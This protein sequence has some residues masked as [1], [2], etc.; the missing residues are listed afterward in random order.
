MLCNFWEHRQSQLG[1]TLQQ[2][3]FRP[4]LLPSLFL[5]CLI[6]QEASAQT[7]VILRKLIFVESE[8]AIVS[9]QNDQDGDAAVYANDIPFL[10]S[11]EANKALSP[12]IGQQI[13]IPLI[14]QIGGIVKE[15]A[16]KANLSAEL[17][18]PNQDARNGV[19]RLIVRSTKLA[20][21]EAF[22][23]KK[24][25]FGASETTLAAI[26]ADAGGSA[27]AYSQDFPF[28]AD[29]EA[30]KA[31]APFVGKQ[32]TMP[33]LNEIGGVVKA[34]A[35]KNDRVV[36]LVL[37]GQDVKGGT[38][39]YL[40]VPTKLIGVR[41]RGN[42]WFSNKVL[43]NNLGIKLGS[44]IRVSELEDAVNWTNTNPFRQIRVLVNKNGNET[45]KAELVVG[46]DESRPYRLIG[47]YD[48]SGTANAGRNRYTAAVQFG[49]LW[50][51]DHQ[52]AYQ[53]V[54]TED[55]KVYNGHSLTYTI[56][57][58]WRN[59]LEL[60]ASYST[61][62]PTGV[63]VYD[64]LKG[65]SRGGSIRYRIPTGGAISSTEYFVG[66]DAQQSN[67]VA[68]FGGT[69]EVFA[70]KVDLFKAMAGVT[71]IRRDRFGGWWI[72]LTGSIS[73]GDL[74]HRN[75]EESFSPGER[76]RYG[77][78][79]VSLQRSIN[80][81]HEF[82]FASRLYGQLSSA[83][84]PSNEHLSIGGQNTVRGYESGV[85]SS[86]QGIV[87]SNDLYF[88]SWK[89]ALPLLGK[90]LPQ[91]ETRFLVFYDAAAVTQKINYETT[92]GFGR[93]VGWSDDDLQT[94]ASTGFGLRMSLANNFSLSFDYGWHTT[95]FKASDQHGRGNI[96]V[97]LAY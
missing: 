73:P 37:P 89:H 80:L 25:I 40:V 92:D 67:I 33:L 62:Q 72:G 17:T 81:S 38:V 59:Y 24:L 8:A 88:P 47:S 14:E 41:F 86:D 39:R 6:V 49:D 27:I 16:N 74:D 15:L 70:R 30:I 5:L 26:P 28:L 19:V 32:I 9:T 93:H 34:L 76:A 57:T 45:G 66:V 18:L 84:L 3:P 13:T 56:P 83:D 75:A 65:I 79:T 77:I 35:N 2:M 55:Y 23:L 94:I 58:P 4:H 63:Q 97:V 7:A 46:V 42:R 11:E 44:E 87:L 64:N 50:G 29:K 91:I 48:N 85:M 22:Y 36:E 90:M 54:T 43:E 53:F 10:T 96:K 78:A 82:V 20:P 71:A 52:A 31:L 21:P 69:A 1:R 60:N 61:T 95:H 12:F 51:K 68:G